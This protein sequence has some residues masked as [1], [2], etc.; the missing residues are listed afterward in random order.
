MASNGCF[1]DEVASRK[2]SN[3]AHSTVSFEGMKM[4]GSESAA[5]QRAR[6]IVGKILV[7]V[8][9]VTVWGLLLLP[10]IF[11][12]LPVRIQPKDQVSSSCS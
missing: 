4:V 7:G 2:L 8:L 3:G 12:H 1:T 9:M 11:Y 10:I 6:V 5:Q